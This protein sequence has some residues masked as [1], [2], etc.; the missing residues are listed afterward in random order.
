MKMFFA[1]AAPGY[2]FFAM[3]ASAGDIPLLLRRENTMPGAEAPDRPLRAP[4][5]KAVLRPNRRRFFHADVTDASD[6]LRRKRRFRKRFGSD[7]GAP[8]DDVARPLHAPANRRLF[9]ITL[10]LR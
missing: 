2:I 9:I 7:D 8:F 10:R 4:T 6:S 5:G 3:H 1:I